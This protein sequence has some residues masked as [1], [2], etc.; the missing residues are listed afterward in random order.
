MCTLS[1]L[2]SK[3]CLVLGE[4]EAVPSTRPCTLCRLA[5]DQSTDWEFLIEDRKICATANA[6]SLGQAER[7][8]PDEEGKEPDTGLNYLWPG[9]HDQGSPRRRSRRKPLNQ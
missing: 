6:V 3:R 1:I 2:F 7:N 4:H 8:A 5:V 9:T